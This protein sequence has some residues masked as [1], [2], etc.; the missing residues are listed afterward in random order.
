MSQNNPIRLALFGAGRIGQVHAHN[1][2]ASPEVELVVIADPFLDGAQKLAAVTGAEAVASP[3]EVFSRDDI[4]GV[5]IG[6]PTSTHVDLITRAVDKGLSVLCEKPIDLEI[7]TVR[8]CRE[9]IDERASQ[10]MLGF[11]RRFDP[12]FA[13]VQRRVTE[14]EIGNLEQIVIISR[15]PAPA[16]R[17]YIAGSGG[18]FRDMTIHDLDMARF[19]VPDIVEVTASGTNV[20]SEEIASFDDYDSAVVTLKGS[21][22]ELVNIV[23]SR[24]CAFGYD[25][26]LEA[27]GEQGM[28]TASNI[29]PTT[30]KKFSSTGTELG[31]PHM[32]FF[33]ERYAQAYLAELEAFARGIRENKPFSPN[34]EDGVIALELA[35]AAV[36]SAATGRSVALEPIAANS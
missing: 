32:P 15:D 30:V 12:S 8:A 18:I 19:F 29:G 11:N 17:E 4:D 23:N 22:G 1:I 2:A 21:K 9:A 27:F 14:G 24:H 25:Q 34:F 16:P 35:N 26:R 7:E 31:D 13:A 5:V 6:S 33:L 20:F 28:L 3:E 36:E 10:V